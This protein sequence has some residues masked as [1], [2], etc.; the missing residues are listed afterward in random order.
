MQSGTWCPRGQAE[1]MIALLKSCLEQALVG[2]RYSY[3]E[4]T[5]VVAEAAQIFNSQPISRGTE[6][7]MV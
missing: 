5:I 2:R 7:P 4:L 3:G 6:D 1:R